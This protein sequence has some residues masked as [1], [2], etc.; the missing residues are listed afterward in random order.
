M[1]SLMNLQAIAATSVLYQF[2]ILMALQMHF[3]EINCK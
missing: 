2:A 3:V 1:I